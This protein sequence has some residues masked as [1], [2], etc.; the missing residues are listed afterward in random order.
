MAGGPKA[1]SEQS[2]AGRVSVWTCSREEWRR[3]FTRQ[4]PYGSDIGVGRESLNN[5][6]KRK[7]M[8]KRLVLILAVVAAG[9][10]LT[11]CNTLEGAGEDIE[12]TGEEL[13][14]A[15]Q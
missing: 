2:A 11:A 9:F 3:R 12:N 6:R 8:I 1:W 7:I 14:E 4:T 15:T 10:A 5:E 13:Q